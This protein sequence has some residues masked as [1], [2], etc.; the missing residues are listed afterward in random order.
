MK[1]RPESWRKY[2]EIHRDMT[3]DNRA[4]DGKVEVADG[5]YTSRFFPMRRASK[6]NDPTLSD[7][8]KIGCSSAFGRT[9][10]NVSMFY[11]K[12]PRGDYLADKLLN[13]ARNGCQVSIVYGAPSVAIAE[14]LREAAGRNLI[15]L[16][17]S[18]WDFNN[19][20]YNEIRT[21]AKYVIVKGAYGGDRSHHIVMTGS[22][23][24]VS[25]SLS[26]GDEVT[27]NIELASAWSDYMRDWTA[28]R[29]HSRRL[30]V[31]PLTDRE[32]ST[33]PTD[34]P[35]RVVLHV[36]APKSGTTYLQRL[37][38][39]NRDELAEAGLHLPGGNQR[40]MFHAAIEV[41]E[42]GERWGMDADELEGTW[43]RL[44][45]QAREVPGTTVM[46]HELLAAAT[47][48]QVGRA[49]SHLEGLDL[50]VVYTAREIS[51]QLVSEWQEN[52]KNGS[53]QSFAQFRRK[54]MAAQTPED[55]LFWRYQNV[56]EALGRW[57]ADLPRDHVHVVVAPVGG[58][59]PAELWRRFAVAC[60]FGPE[61]IADPVVTDAANQ[62]LGMTQVHLLR[63]VV[64]SLEGRIE[65][66]EYA[67]IVKRLF[68]QRI[69]AGQSSPRP[70]CPPD[71]FE[72]LTELSAEW[73]QGI[74]ERGYRVHGDL[75]ELRPPAPTEGGA[76]RTTCARRG[77]RRAAAAI[78]ELLRGGRRRRA[79]ARRAAERA[80][81]V[82]AGRRR[83]STRPVGSRSPAVRGGPARPA[84]GQLSRLGAKSL[85]PAR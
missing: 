71:L 10:V 78:A 85:R 38:W 67:R 42:V 32:V 17:D 16:F 22:Q 72:P 51:R 40:D 9:K 79:Q 12:G 41:R 7:L 43:A 37:L 36:G 64:G 3:E 39:Q 34:L 50:H 29:N 33:P 30:P 4:G 25:G 82:D 6:S 24:W 63:R 23:N 75:A 61:S 74:E 26:R 5:P 31:Q 13:L 70:T 59:E 47:P 66:P 1:N 49:L 8:N 53:R 58:S 15:D 73:I 68:A 44:C 35:R 54:V 18:R 77:A 48:E 81:R 69:L 83:P 76:R 45:E 46:S 14:R 27:L 65:Q 62:T 2:V 28:I 55:H 19:D 60:G 80:T 11:W 20:G 56:V 52:V 57:G 21:H 84:R